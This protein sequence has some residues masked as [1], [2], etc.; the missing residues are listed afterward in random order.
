MDEIE[1]PFDAPQSVV[2]LDQF[3]ICDGT[4]FQLVLDAGDPLA[5]ARERYQDVTYSAYKVESRARQELR[6]NALSYV[7]EDPIDVD[8][9][10]S[11]NPARAGPVR[12][13]RRNASPVK[14]AR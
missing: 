12:L 8:S 10:D 4:R 14:T 11:K 13:S 2:E 9:P 1:G 3:D 6:I 7:L 5:I